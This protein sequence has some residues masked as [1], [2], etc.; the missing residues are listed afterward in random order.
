MYFSMVG[1]FET[2]A[3][4][5]LEVRVHVQKGVLWFRGKIGNICPR[6]ILR[7]LLSYSNSPQ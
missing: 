7:P 2:T 5:H 4:E 3:I 1:T 6:F